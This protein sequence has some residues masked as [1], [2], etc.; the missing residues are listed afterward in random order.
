[1]NELEVNMVK[2]YAKLFIKKSEMNGLTVGE[3]K[4]LVEKYT[5][6]FTKKHLYIS[7]ESTTIALKELGFE[8]NKEGYLNGSLVYPSF[9]I[10]VD[11]IGNSD[12]EKNFEKNNYQIP[13][14][15]IPSMRVS[16][17]IDA[18]SPTYINNGNNGFPFF[19]SFLY[20]Q[21][22]WI[23]IDGGLLAYN[24]NENE[25]TLDVIYVTTKRIG[26]GNK[27]FELF[28]GEIL[29]YQEDC[30][31]EI[32]AFTNDSKEFFKEMN[33]KYSFFKPSKKLKKDNTYSIAIAD[34]KNLN[35]I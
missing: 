27:L 25:I 17:M 18:H 12:F 10:L 33:K 8:V 24:K 14:Y 7:R 9:N 3:I 29:N 16:A 34:I 31:I 13:F 15:R 21:L 4:H 35:I 6:Y 2:K 20:K 22:K 28:I 23:E 11:T 19:D 5:D 1:M 30:I 32:D 26:I